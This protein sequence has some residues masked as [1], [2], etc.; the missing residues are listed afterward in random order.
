MDKRC[1]QTVARYIS[2]CASHGTPV[3]LTTIM[4]IHVAHGVDASEEAIRRRM[5][6]GKQLFPVLVS[7][8]AEL[9]FEFAALETGQRTQT[10]CKR[11]GSSYSCINHFV[12]FLYHSRDG[13]YCTNGALLERVPALEA[14]LPVCRDLVQLGIPAKAYTSHCSTFKHK[15]IQL[16]RKRRVVA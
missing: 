9:W 10:T 15:F 1:K 4:S 8:A 14:F 13:I 5:E 11:M 16:M 12:A 7:N 3:S 6:H 2:A